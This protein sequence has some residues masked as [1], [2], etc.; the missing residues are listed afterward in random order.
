MGYQGK[1]ILLFFNSITKMF[2]TFPMG[3]TTFFP[4]VKMLTKSIKNTEQ[5]EFFSITINTV[6]N[7]NN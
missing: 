3:S 7:F 2:D 6:F 1:S 4:E 5:F